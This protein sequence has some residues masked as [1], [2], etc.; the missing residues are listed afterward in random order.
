MMDLR[1]QFDQV[2]IVSDLFKNLKN[3][4]FV[5]AGAYDGK[6]FSNSLFFEVKQGWTGLLVEPNPDALDELV[7]LDNYPMLGQFVNLLIL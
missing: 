1:G 3:G 4:F 7:V 2:K 6:I 5:E